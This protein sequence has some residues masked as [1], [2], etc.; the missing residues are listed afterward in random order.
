MKRYTFFLAIFLLFPF[1]FDVKA[2]SGGTDANGGHNCSAT[3]ISSGLCTGYHYHNGSGSYTPPAA[4]PPYTSKVDYDNGYKAGYTKGLEMGYER[5]SRKIEPSSGNADFIKGWSLGYQEGFDKGLDKIGKEEDDKR[6][7]L[8]A[9]TQARKDG[10]AAFVSGKAET[11]YQYSTG[12]SAI[13][14]A[15]YE[16]AFKLAWNQKE[17][18]EAGYKQGLE[19]DAIDMPEK[20]QR[21]PIDSEYKKGYY[22]AVRKRDVAEMTKYKKEGHALGYAAKELILPQNIAKDIYSDAFVKAYDRGIKKREEEVRG[23]GFKFAFEQV[24]FSTPVYE[25]ENLLTEWFTEGYESNEIAAEIKS[26]ASKLGEESKEYIIPEEYQVS[27]EAVALYDLLFAE[28]QDI[29]ERKQRNM[30]MSVGAVVILIIGGVFFRKSLP[31]KSRFS[32]IK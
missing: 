16:E 26:V 25:G 32:Y 9:R 1:S 13:F 17:A 20:F 4:K 22:A 23:E 21:K 28:G 8:E 3:S 10:T 14:I 30:L 29:R 5:E 15:T 31:L 19:Q 24:E 6:V 7:K 27:E 18:Y 12:H 2:H 11:A